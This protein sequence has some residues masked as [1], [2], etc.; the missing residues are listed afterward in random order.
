MFG[1]NTSLWTR[2]GVAAY[3]VKSIVMYMLCV[4][5]DESELANLVAIIIS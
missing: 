1:K 2:S 3:C 5:Q 4:V